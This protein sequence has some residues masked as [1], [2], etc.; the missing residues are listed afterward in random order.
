MLA[1]LHD[2]TVVSKT[3]TKH[4]LYNGFLDD[5]ASQ[6]HIFRLGLDNLEKKAAP[7][8]GG[9]KALGAAE[10]AAASTPA[11]AEAAAA[12]ED[13]EATVTVLEVK[14]ERPST[15]GLGF[16]LDG[17]PDNR[18]ILNRGKNHVRPDFLGIYNPLT[19]VWVE[20]PKK[21]AIPAKAPIKMVPRPSTADSAFNPITNQRV[22]GAPSTSEHPI[23]AFTS[24]RRMVPAPGAGDAEIVPA[25]K[26]VTK[27]PWLGLYDPVVGTWIE[28]PSDKAF[29]KREAELST[30]KFLMDTRPRTPAP[31]G[32]YNP[33]KQVWVEL[34]KEPKYLEREDVF[35]GLMRKGKT[36]SPTKGKREGIIPERLT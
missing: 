23:K 36:E 19:H 20:E 14:V 10:V 18:P 12:S 7:V 16:W 24:R 26:L 4:I 25:G 9:A 8:V 15:A 32:D 29:C 3:K 27:P 13:S 33:I 35:P 2:H 1:L 17:L 6:Y 28:E 11:P 21:P 31:F 5:L 22:D 30:G 34:P